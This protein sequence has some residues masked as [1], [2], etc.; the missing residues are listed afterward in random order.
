[1][2]QPQNFTVASDLASNDVLYGARG[3]GVGSERQY[4]SSLLTPETVLPDHSAASSWM[5][6]FAPW[7]YAISAA[8]A[9]PSN[10]REWWLLCRWHKP[11]AATVANAYVSVGSAGT[12]TFAI[13]AATAT[14]GIGARLDRQSTDVSVSTTLKSFTLASSIPSGTFFWLV[15]HIDS[16]ATMR[17]LTGPSFAQLMGVSSTTGEPVAARVRDSIT[18]ANAAP[19]SAPALNSLNQVNNLSNCACVM[20]G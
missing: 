9:A 20:F 7:P 15:S 17:L 16:L 8:T 18:A 12:F 1:M 11:S 19:S 4:A 3:T 2:T 13:Y 14:L 5:A 6:R 10:Q